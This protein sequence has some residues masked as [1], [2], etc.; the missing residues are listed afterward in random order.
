[1]YDKVQLLQPLDAELTALA[2]LTSA[3]NKIPYFTGSGSASL[4]DFIPGAWTAFTPTLGGG[5]ALGNSTYY[6][7]YARIGR[8]VFFSVVITAGTTMTKGTALTIALPV[9]AAEEGNVV[10][11]VTGFVHDVG[12]AAYYC[13]PAF[14]TTTLATATAVSLF[15]MN[16]TSTYVGYVAVSSTVPFA[17]GTSDRIICVGWYEAST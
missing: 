7:V 13:V 4:A 9:T 12:A 10:G 6:A 17:F 1:M 5:W 15:A 8:M 14:T 16:A 2:G 11:T 3:A